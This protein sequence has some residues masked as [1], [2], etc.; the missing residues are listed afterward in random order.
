MA[1]P[2]NADEVQRASF[3]RASD[4]VVETWDRWTATI[5]AVRWS[6]WS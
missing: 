1:V 6:R 2:A 4:R 3:D 5:C